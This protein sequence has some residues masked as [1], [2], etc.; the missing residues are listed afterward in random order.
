MFSSAK[1]TAPAPTFSGMAWTD[2]TFKQIS[3]SDYAGKYV[4]LFFYPLDFTFVCPTEICAFNDSAAH[5]K[6]VNCELIACSVDSHFTHM[7]YTKKPR[8]EGGLGEM[9][10]PMLSDLTKKISE[11]Y[12]V[13]TPDNAIAFRGTFIIDKSGILRHSS[14]N[15]LPVGRNPEETLRLVKAF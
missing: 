15:D 4:V 3:L 13:L 6:D 9:S 11:D 7:E 2:G 5:F 14:I 12:G 1:I 8:A 10:I